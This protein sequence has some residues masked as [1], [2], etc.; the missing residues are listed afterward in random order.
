VYFVSCSDNICEK[1]AILVF[2][3]LNQLNVAG[4]IYLKVFG[5]YRLHVFGLFFA[6]NKFICFTNSSMTKEICW[7]IEDCP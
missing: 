5:D 6:N 3:D 2:G 7:G 4:N 1:F